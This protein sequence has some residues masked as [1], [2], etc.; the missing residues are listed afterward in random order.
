MYSHEEVTEWAENNNVPEEEVL[1]E[2]VRD[3]ETGVIESKTFRRM[4][5]WER[6]ELLS[7]YEP[8]HEGVWL[9]GTLPGWNSGEQSLTK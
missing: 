3:M 6:L 9:T 1:C 4:N 8:K 7:D 5:F 2:I